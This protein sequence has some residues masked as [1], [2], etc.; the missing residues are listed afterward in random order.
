MIKRAYLVKK[1]TYSIAII[2]QLGLRTLEPT[3][4]KHKSLI[5]PFLKRRNL[6]FA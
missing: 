4:R 2:F 6:K 5:A 3:Q 1:K